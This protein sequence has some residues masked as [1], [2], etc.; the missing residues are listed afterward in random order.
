LLINSFAAEFLATV[1]KLFHCLVVE[2]LEWSLLRL[3]SANK[4]KLHLPV[5][6]TRTVA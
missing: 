6:T 5:V 3:N 2:S 4:I 1:A